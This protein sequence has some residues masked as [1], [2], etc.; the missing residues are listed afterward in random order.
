MTQSE[1]IGLTKKDSNGCWIWTRS[2]TPR[3]YGHAWNDGK[4]IR[5]HRLSY[6][7]FRGPIPDGLLVCHRC[8]NPSCVN[9]DHL[10]LGTQSENMIDAMHKGRF[11]PP[12]NQKRTHCHK[13]HLYSP[14]NI[15][16]AH[17]HR[18]CRICRIEADRQR[19]LRRKLR[20][21]S[22]VGS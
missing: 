5:A 13:G 6:E 20:K 14:E 9:P 8:D 10:F 1:L 22:E 11:R 12:I 15:E 19:Y 18:T 3:G 17:G 4:E 21:K 2:K 7:I 16:M